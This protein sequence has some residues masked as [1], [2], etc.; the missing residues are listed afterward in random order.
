MRRILVVLA[1]VVMVFIG[2]GWTA[3]AHAQGAFRT[4]ND[5]TVPAGQT[6][7]SSLFMSGRTIDI[8]GTVDGDVY[9]AG[10]DVSVTGH[11]TG[12][13]ICVGQTVDVTGT[14]GGNIRV[15]GQTV[16]I[17]GATTHSLTA[18]GQS[19]TLAAS[20]TVGGDAAIGS[21]NVALDGAIGRDL[22]LG[23]TSATIN[24]S[25]GRDVQ[26]TVTDL[27]LGNGSRIGGNL[28]YVSRHEVSRAGG[29][30]VGGTVSRQEPRATESQANPFGALIGGSFMFALYMFVALLVVALAL[31]LLVPQFIHDATEVAVRSPWKTLLV[32][33]VA[34]IVVPAIIFAL[35]LTLIGAPLAI[36]LL[37]SWIVIV[38]VAVPFAAYYLGSLLISKSTDSPIWIMLLGT[39]IIL[40]LYLIP[41]VGFLVWLVATWF[42][43]GIILLQYSHLPRPHYSTQPAKR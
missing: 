19:V 13:V 10:Q 20:G 5:V 34:S 23:A 36:L 29:A 30:A 17:G 40:V 4:G 1:I 14:V 7:D 9:C 2:V 35:M 42:G 11:V 32:G 33:I 22:T 38:G 43:L 6:V 21:Q 24:G 41:I 37:L 12:D 26:A 28:A 15:A 8:A 27:T 39:A 25:V 18:A 16:T 3:A 31:V